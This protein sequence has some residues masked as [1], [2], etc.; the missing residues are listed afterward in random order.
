MRIRADA[1][2]II[3]IAI[4]VLLLYMAAYA[5]WGVVRTIADL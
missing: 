3:N 2:L 1:R 4:A 5:V